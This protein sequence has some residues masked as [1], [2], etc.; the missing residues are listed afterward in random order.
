MNIKSNNF[1]KSLIYTLY[2]FKKYNIIIKTKQK[3]MV[4][5]RNNYNITE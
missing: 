3:H 1:T 4:N 2:I 5:M